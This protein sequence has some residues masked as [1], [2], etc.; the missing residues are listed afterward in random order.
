MADHVNLPFTGVSGRLTSGRGSVTLINFAE[1]SAAAAAAVQ[2]FDGQDTGGV[3]LP[4]IQIPSGT[5]QLCSIG[6]GQLTFTR[7]L[8]VNVVSGTVKGMVAALLIPSD[9]EWEEFQTI[10]GGSY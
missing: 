9:A 8:Y 7:G 2:L 10:W 4:Y 5:T 6:R 1:T 3:P